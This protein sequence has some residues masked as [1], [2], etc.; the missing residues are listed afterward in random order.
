MNKSYDIIIVGAGVSGLMLAKLLDDSKLKVLLI[1]NRST[2]KKLWNHRYGTFKETVEKF[3]LEKYVIKKYKK[4]AFGMSELEKQTVLSYHDYRFQ[5]VDMN[6]FAK[7]L[8]LKC[9]VLT[10][11]NI[12]KIRRMNGKIV[13]FNKNNKYAANIVVDCSGCSQVVS[14]HLKR[15]EKKD[16]IN[17]LN[18]FLELS[19]CN[20]P[21]EFTDRVYFPHHFL[22]MNIPLCLYPYSRTECQFGHSDLVSNK[23][24]LVKGQAKSIYLFMQNEEPYKTW[25]KDAKV[26]EKVRKISSTTITRSLVDDNFI[27]C[28]EAG[29]ATTPMLGE[30]FRIA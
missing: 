23:F 30:G 9:D 22:Y 29:G 15:P 27:A 7:D 24:P 28:G 12:K 5:I 3:N 4:F 8:K 2:I 14:H 21:K 17:F 11:F 13:I 25:F 10:K 26:K 1:E 18:T 16:S 20:I 19:N 6:L